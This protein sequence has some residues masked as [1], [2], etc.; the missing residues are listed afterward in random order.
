MTYLSVIFLPA[1]ILTWCCIGVLGGDVLVAVST[2]GGPPS[3]ASGVARD[4]ARILATAALLAVSIHLLVVTVAKIPSQESVLGGPPAE[5]TTE[6]VVTFVRG[7]VGRDEPFRLQVA[8]PQPLYAND[9]Q[10]GAAY[11][12]YVDGWKVHLPGELGDQIGS[13]VAADPRSA[14]IR[15]AVT[16]RSSTCGVAPGPSRSGT[17]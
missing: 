12:L 16:G 14:L 13:S 8:A 2:A 6:Q 5:S 7:H 1:G 11:Q 3:P 10:M 15:C 4:A 9:V 17:P